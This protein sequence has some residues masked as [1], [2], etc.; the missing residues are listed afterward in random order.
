MLEGSRRSL[1]QYIENVLCLDL[2]GN[3]RHRIPRMLC[4]EDMCDMCPLCTFC[5]KANI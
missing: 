3:H 5:D 1:A 2:G 4:T